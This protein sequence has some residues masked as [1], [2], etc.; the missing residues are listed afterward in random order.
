MPR[1]K[2]SYASGGLQ[3]PIPRQGWQAETLYPGSVP[4]RGG[5]LPGL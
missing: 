4:E 2:V 1:E 3:A 5:L